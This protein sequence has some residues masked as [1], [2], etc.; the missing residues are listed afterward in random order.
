MIYFTE[1]VL[2]GNTLHRQWLCK[3]TNGRCKSMDGNQYDHFFSKNNYFDQIYPVDSKRMA[4]DYLKLFFEQFGVKQ[5]LTVDGSKEQACKG[6][7]LMKYLHSQDIGYHISE[8]DL[9][10]QNPF[11]GFVME[12]R[13]KQYRT[14]VNKLVLRQL[15]EYGVSWISEVM[16]MTHSSENSVNGGINL[17][18]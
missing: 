18:I 11:E 6:A 7:T 4:G 14:M 12:A 3:T 8:P 17:E 16:S 13:R 15:W 2:K 1:I 9:H 5:K 10:K